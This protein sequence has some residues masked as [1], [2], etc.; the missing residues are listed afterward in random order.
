MQSYQA[1]PE[2]AQMPEELILIETV[3][4]HQ[5]SLAL[6]Y[7]MTANTSRSATSISMTEYGVEIQQS[8]PS[9]RTIQRSYA[10]CLTPDQEEAEEIVQFLALHTVTPQQ[11]HLVLEEFWLD[12]DTPR[13]PPAIL[14]W[15]EQQL[16]SDSMRRKLPMVSR[17]LQKLQEREQLLLSDGI[18]FTF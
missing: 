16:I 1:K 13:V 3:Q 15:E 6:S 4:L 5:A 14:T 8:T 9:S 12:T 10:L 17:D 7:Y 18:T 11:L 2:F